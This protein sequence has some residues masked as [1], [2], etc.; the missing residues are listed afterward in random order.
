MAIEVVLT[1]T[2]ADPMIRNLTLSE[3][4]KTLTLPRFAELTLLGGADIEKL[5]NLPIDSVTMLRQGVGEASI[6]AGVYLLENGSTVHV[7]V[8]HGASVK[9]RQVNVYLTIRSPSITAFVDSYALALN[10]KLYGLELRPK[11]TA[12]FRQVAQDRNL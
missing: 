1:K 4:G 5:L 9:F 6:S 12:T 3:D 11:D 7:E 10:N 8:Q 2:I